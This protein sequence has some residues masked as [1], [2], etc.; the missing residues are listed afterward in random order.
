MGIGFDPM[1][2]EGPLVEAA[3]KGDG[4]AFAELVRRNKSAV[5]RLAARFART[6]SEVEDLAQE[7]FF[8]AFRELDGFRGEAAFSTW[9]RK[10]A[11]SCC[12]SALKRNKTIPSLGGDL[13]FEIVDE[14]GPRALAA[15]E[16]R[17]TLDKLMARLDPRDRVIITLLELEGES[18]EQ[19]A[20]LTGMSQINVRVR[21]HRA[22]AR[23][24]KFLEA[25][26]DG[27][28]G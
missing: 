5:F 14:R 18:V 27:R 13:D 2:A 12:L 25:D 9:L 3:K 26:H 17:D 16:A 10:V 28:T 6:R 1:A 8:K 11:A 24:R 7:T 15:L 20:H 21:A 4:R 23:L 22:R 19:T